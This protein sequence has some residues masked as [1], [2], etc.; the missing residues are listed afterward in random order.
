MKFF[1]FNATQHLLEINNFRSNPCCFSYIEPNLFHFEEF[2]LNKHFNC[3]LSYFAHDNNIGKENHGI[4]P[5]INLMQKSSS[6]RI[7]EIVL[8]FVAQG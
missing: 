7:L 4:Q 1:F 3:I 5:D 8:R 6:Q 2:L